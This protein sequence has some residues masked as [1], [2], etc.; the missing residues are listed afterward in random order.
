MQMISKYHI[1]TR[2][3]RFFQATQLHNNVKFT[4]YHIL[5]ILLAKI[6]G[7]QLIK[8]ALLNY[9]CRYFDIKSQILCEIKLLTTVYLHF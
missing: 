6:R 2:H 3:C 1:P 7:F 5:K 4:D 9:K 8:D